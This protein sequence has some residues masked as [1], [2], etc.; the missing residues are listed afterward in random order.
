VNL[1]KELIYLLS[2]SENRS[3]VKDVVVQLGLLDFEE[4][5]PYRQYVGSRHL[6]VDVLFEHDV[7]K[8][9]QVFTKN[10]QG[11]LAF[12]EELPFGLVPGMSQHEVH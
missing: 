3:D 11:F 5:P 2:H 4:D 1:L 7:M 9:V 6:G 10:M 8:A 12:P